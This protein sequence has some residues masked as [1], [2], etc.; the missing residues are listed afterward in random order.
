MH[1]LLSYLAKNVISDAPTIDDVSIEESKMMQS[2]KQ[3]NSQSNVFYA[4]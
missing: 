4:T 3:Q 2:N 1:L